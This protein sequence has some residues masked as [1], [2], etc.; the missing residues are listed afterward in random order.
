MKRKISITIND[1]TLDDIDT[2][3]DNIYIRNRSQAIELLVNRALG[4]NKCA[5]ILAGGPED[6]LKISSS[7]YRL[8]GKIDS[9]TVIESAISKLKDEGFSKVW[10]I[11][12]H[13]VI[14]AIFNIIQNGSKYGVEI[15]Y[16]EE[17][18]SEGTADSLRLIKGEIQSNFLVVYGDLYFKNINIEELW[19]THLKQKGTAS[20]LLNVTQDPSKKGIVKLEGSKILEFVQKP[21][22]SD[23]YLGF[24]SMF[25][26]EPELL[27]YPGASLEQDVFPVLASKR[28][29]TGYL[30]TSKIAKI[31]SKD[32]LSMIEP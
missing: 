2:I 8:T 9:L 12:R 21:K 13:K 25:V 22:H 4:D 6:D 5:V 27:E 14:S 19:N 26:A 10:V 17:V 16:K 20:L 30:S 32:D 7:E 15:K 29:L 1:K 28:L 31:H 3:I 18:S 11:A 24:A 23:I